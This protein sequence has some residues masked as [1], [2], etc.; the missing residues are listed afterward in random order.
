MIRWLFQILAWA[1]LLGI[2]AATLSPIGLR[3]HLPVGV[4][5]ER[6]LAFLLLGALFAVAYPKRIGLVL[7]LVFIAAFG[8]EYLQQLRPDRHARLA[9]ACYKALGGCLGVGLAYVIH[10]ALAWLRTRRLSA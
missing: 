3:P 8:L 1:V 7:V 5:L 9:D 10:Y 4:N 2:A 6:S